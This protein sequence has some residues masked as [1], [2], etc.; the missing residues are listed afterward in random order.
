MQR[1]LFLL[2]FLPVALLLL[3]SCAELEMPPLNQ[4]SSTLS[5]DQ[6]YSQ[7]KS[8]IE[9]NPKLSIM[10]EVN[11]QANA[12]GAGL[13]MPPSRL[14][15]FG[16]PNMGTPLMKA[17][18]TTAID[19]PQK[20]LVYQNEQGQTLIAYNEPAHLALRHG[21]S[22]QADRLQKMSAALDGI[23]EEGVEE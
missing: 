8:A 16:N 7:I 21:I 9:S 3:P 5:V 11:H 1:S 14:I 10:A 12:A 6:A 13:D 18:P 15:V 2:F 20:I 22:G 17:S 19:L 4:R 23:A